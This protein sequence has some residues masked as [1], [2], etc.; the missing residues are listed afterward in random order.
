MSGRGGGGGGWFV[1][2]VCEAGEGRGVRGEGGGRGRMWR[3]D[4]YGGTV[5]RTSGPHCWHP[6][7][8]SRGGI[9]CILKL[10]SHIMHILHIILHILHIANKK[11]QNYQNLH[12]AAY[13][14]AY[15][16]AYFAY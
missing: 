4:R 3:R 2:G 15:Y 12:I 9:F 16:L 7:Q 1:V 8:E 14:F 5:S 11:Q 10:C 13:Y 6:S